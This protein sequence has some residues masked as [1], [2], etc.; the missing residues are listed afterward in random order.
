MP[1]RLRA[2]TTAAL[3][4]EDGPVLEGSL[5][6]DDGEEDTVSAMHGN[7]DDGGFGA[8]YAPVSA[9]PSLTRESQIP[10]VEPQMAMPAQPIASPLPD[11][12]MSDWDG[13]MGY[14][15]NALM[16][17]IN[18]VS[19]HRTLMYLVGSRRR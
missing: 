16:D 7:G 4:P 1:Q 12:S 19:W 11:P 6:A 5:D 18:E 8:E 15:V 3:Y 9:T 14:D 2:K 13:S 10:T 17:L